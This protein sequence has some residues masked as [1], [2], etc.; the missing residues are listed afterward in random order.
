MA[1]RVE[2]IGDPVLG[3][4]LADNQQAD[5]ALGV[6]EKAVSDPCSR[7]EGDPI[8]RPQAMEFAVDPGIGAT[9]DDI[10]EFLVPLMGMRL[11]AAAARRNRLEIDPQPA[12]TEPPAEG[13]SKAARSP[14]PVGSS[15][16]V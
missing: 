14:W 12:E 1:L 3:M 5:R 8:A 15:I 10:D 11:G 2:G 6:V 16:S 4:V 9:L 13:R 7:R